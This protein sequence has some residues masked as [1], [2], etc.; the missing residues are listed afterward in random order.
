M[1]Y[2]FAGQ[3]AK[4]DKYGEYLVARRILVGRESALPFI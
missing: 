2:A 1:R 4:S 3:A